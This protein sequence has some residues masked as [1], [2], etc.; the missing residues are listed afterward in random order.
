MSGG[1]RSRSAASLPTTASLVSESSRLQSGSG[2]PPVSSCWAVC[3][4]VQRE[5]CR[6]VVRCIAD[7]PCVCQR[8]EHAC[9]A[10]W[11]LFTSTVQFQPGRASDLS[12]LTSRTVTMP[13]SASQHETKFASRRCGTC[14]KVADRSARSVA[15]TAPNLCASV[16][17]RRWQCVG[18]RRPSDSLRSH[19]SVTSRTH[20]GPKIAVPIRTMV[21]PSATAAS[22]SPVMPIERVSSPKSFA[23]RSSRIS[24]RSRKGMR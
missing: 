22:R 23:L 5:G 1:R 19:S 12:A 24:R 20:R 2:A 13:V 14:A 18:R 4:S 21:A 16:L 15:A 10:E 9:S 3:D 17:S 6:I 8:S 7:R 11:T